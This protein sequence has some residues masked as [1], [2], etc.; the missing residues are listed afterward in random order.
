MTDSLF[1]PEVLASRSANQLGAIR[2]RQPFAYRVW[3]L[4]ALAVLGSIISFLAFASVTQRATV[5]GV[6][7]PAGGIANLASPLG[8]TLIRVGAQ[9]GQTV[10]AGDVL[11]VLST[12]RQQVVAAGA[13]AGTLGTQAAIAAQLATRQLLAE[14]DLRRAEERFE[15]RER[16]IAERLAVLE[17][18]LIAVE[19]ER[20]LAASRLQLAESQAGRINELARAGFVSAGQQASQQDELLAARQPAQ[21]LERSRIA[22]E[23]ERAS[24]RGQLRDAQ[25][26]RETELAEARKARALLAQESTENAARATHV[27]TAPYAGT[28]TGSAVM[29]GQVVTPGQVLALLVPHNPTV[30]VEGEADPAR[31]AGSV[32]SLQALEAQGEVIAERVRYAPNGSPPARG[33]PSA[34]AHGAPPNPSTLQAHFYIPT[35]AAGF[36]APG[37]TVRLRYAAFPYQKFGQHQGTVLAIDRAP[38]APSQLPPAISAALASTSTGATPEARYRVTVA[39]TEQ[40][41]LAYGQP[42][43]LKP[44][45]VVEADIVQR[46]SKIYEQI[47]DPLRGF[48]QRGI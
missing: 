22:I 13:T 32:P 15:A 44:G 11:F 30:E 7:M 36:V 31:A 19:R 29:V 16:S 37:Q 5:A 20:E 18:E 41:I 27:V 2:I 9:D 4:I 43:P 21:A 28:L 39:L 26:A 10:Q 48:A 25:N 17:R 45:M 3:A 23:R 8:G 35:R 12:D 6:L 47:L 40:Y 24:L 46:E 14:Q 34:D 38:T 1:R 33:P 42:L